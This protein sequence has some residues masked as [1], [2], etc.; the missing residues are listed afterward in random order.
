MLDYDKLSIEFDKLLKKVTKK[1]YEAWLIKD[2]MYKPED[3]LNNI[4][5]KELI[6]TKCAACGKD[7][8][9]HV[10]DTQPICLECFN[11]TFEDAFLTN[12]IKDV[13]KL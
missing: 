5:K 13:P 12:N 11:T 1:D 9:A 8:I 2:N 4:P 6:D 3:M 10:T 7:I